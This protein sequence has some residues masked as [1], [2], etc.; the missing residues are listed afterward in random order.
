MKRVAFL[1]AAM[2]VSGCTTSVDEMS[3]SQLQQYTAGMVEKCQKQN[4][5]QAELRACAEQ[6]MRSDQARRMKQRQ[7]GMAI[8]GASQA[9]GQ[10]M[11]QSAMAN[12]PITCTSTPNSTFVGGPVSSVRTSC[13]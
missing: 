12:R 4:V 6:E 3:Y 7:V 1:F 9:Y 10:G 13:Y 2:A 11:Q 8:A 5:P